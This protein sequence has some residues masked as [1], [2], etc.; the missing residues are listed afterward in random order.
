MPEA[1]TTALWRPVGPAELRQIEAA[2]MRGF[3]PR[4]PDQPIFYPVLSQDYAAKIARDWN[5]PAH[6]ACHGTRFFVR[7]DFLANYPI[8]EAGG[9]A[10]REYWIPAEDLPDF[11]AAIVGAIEVVES[12]PEP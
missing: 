6:G 10:H 11:N 7:K 5:V 2:G 8:R 3:P 1:E 9:G 4:L 12:F